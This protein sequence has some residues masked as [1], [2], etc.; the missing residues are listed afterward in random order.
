MYKVL[1]AGIIAGFICMALTPVLI[2]LLKKMSYGQVIREDG[3]HAHFAKKG[4]PT[5]GGILIVLGTVTGYLVLSRRTPEG[6]LVIGTMAACGLLGFIDDLIQVRNKRSLGLKPSV[7]FL[8]QLVIAVAF[9]IIGTHYCHLSTKLSFIGDTRLDLGV[10]LFILV[11]VMLVGS[12][13]AVNLTD[14]L[15]GLATGSMILV[16]A[17]YLLIAF[18]MFRHPLTLHPRFY[19]FSGQPALDIAIIAGAVMGAC[20]GFLWWNA[21][22]ARIFMGDTGSLALGGVMA[23]T[24]IMTRTEL[25]LIILGGLFVIETLSVIIQVGVFKLTGGR[26]VFK[27]APIHHHFELAGWSEFTVMIRLWIVSGF[28]VVVGFALFYVD[29][30]TRVPS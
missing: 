7:K 26:R 21:A 15:D 30:V 27:M 13:N 22:P 25:L 18:T 5:M 10:F 12:S 3:P 8:V 11:F 2:K 23:A 6:L 20:V 1:A 9:I 17:A 19:K 28:C 14:G 16:M 24:A 29:F 4:T